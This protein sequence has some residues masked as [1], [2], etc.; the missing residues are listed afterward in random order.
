[1]DDKPILSIIKGLS[2]DWVKNN[3]IIIFC[4]L[5]YSIDRRW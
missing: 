1:M 5:S 4:D 3:N 2:A